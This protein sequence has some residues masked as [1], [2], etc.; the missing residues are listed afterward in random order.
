MSK[1]I[2]Q[3]ILLKIPAMQASAKAPLGPTL[4]Q[5][6]IPIADFCKKFNDLTSLY[7]EGTLVKS[8]VTLYDNYEY[9]IEIKN[10]D[11]TFFI[12]KSIIL[13]KGSSTAGKFKLQEN[14][15][16]KQITSTYVL[17]EICKMKYLPGEGIDI[18]S[19]YKTMFGTLKS[20][21]IVVLP[22]SLLGNKTE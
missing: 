18:K 19:L 21:G 4:G 11:V 13:E 12:K 8:R 1:L 14:S 2:K 22:S 3:I 7:V 10:P 9:D 6:G 15:L 5:Y 20:M 16:F 17:Y